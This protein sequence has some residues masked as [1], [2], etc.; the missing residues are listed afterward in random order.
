MVKHYYDSQYM[1][2]QYIFYDMCNLRCYGWKFCVCVKQMQIS[3]CEASQLQ[4]LYICVYV[5]KF[6]RY[7]CYISN[8]SVHVSDVW[9]SRCI[10]ISRY[11][12]SQYHTIALYCILILLTFMELYKEC[13]CTKLCYWLLVMTLL[14][15]ICAE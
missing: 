6:Q 12:I 2:V 3:N 8:H 9:Y 10:D 15:L 4:L 14:V 5:H 7:R 13:S 1:H 11:K